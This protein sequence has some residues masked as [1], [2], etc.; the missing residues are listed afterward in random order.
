VASVGKAELYLKE[1]SKRYINPRSNP[2]RRAK[3]ELS[4]ATARRALTRL[5]EIYQRTKD[6]MLE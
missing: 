6:I 4:E 5:A 3:V 1:P 2:F